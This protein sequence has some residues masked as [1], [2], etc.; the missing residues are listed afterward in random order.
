MEAK[1]EKKRIR[2]T[3]LQVENAISTAMDK[4]VEREGL[5]KITANM[6]MAEANIESPVFYNRYTSIDDLIY[7]YISDKD[8]WVAG[9]LPYKDINK[10]GPEEYYIQ[11]VLKLAKMLYESKFTRDVLAWELKS[12]SEAASRLAGLKE[13]ENEALLVYYSKIFKDSGIDI[14]GI[15]ALLIAGV[16]YLYMHKDKSTFC[17]N[18]NRK[19]YRVVLFLLYYF[20]GC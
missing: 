17:G 11:T 19:K 15:T 16:Y 20:G 14:R 18:R 4:L 12:D 2:R 13:M 5:L 7:E 10:E 1:K 3:N 9:K 6:L 8:F